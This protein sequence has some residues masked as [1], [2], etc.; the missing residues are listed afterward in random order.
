MFCSLPT[1]STVVVIFS[2]WIFNKYC[3]HEILPLIR[4]MTAHLKGYIALAALARDS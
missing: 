2:L 4:L 3:R 1:C